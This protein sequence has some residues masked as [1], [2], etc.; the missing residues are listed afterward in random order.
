M[1]SWE[2]SALS[3]S[4]T[5][6]GTATFCT[7][8]ELTE[9]DRDGQRFVIVACPGFPLGRD[10]RHVISRS[11]GIGSSLSREPV[12]LVG[13]TLFLVILEVRPSRAA[14]GFGSAQGIFRKLRSCK[15]RVL[16]VATY[17]YRK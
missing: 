13:D 11:G 1:D 8:S 10:K 9:T 16:F 12:A 2:K 3:R 14:V 5:G 7:R 15:L 4:P 17:N 6:D